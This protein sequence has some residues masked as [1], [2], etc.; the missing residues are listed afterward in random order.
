M[1][2]SSIW[3]EAFRNIKTGTTR[4][5]T[6]TLLLALVSAT[7]VTAEVKAVEQISAQADAFRQKGASILTLA[8]PGRVDGR[9]CEALA[10]IPG[11]LAAGALRGADSKVVPT[12]L[13]ESPVPAFDVTPGFPPLV[14][15][16]TIG[17]GPLAGPELAQSLDLPHRTSIETREGILPIGGTFSYPSDGRR[18][19]FSYALL[20]PVP[21]NSPFDECWIDVWPSDDG[22]AQLLLTTLLPTGNSTELPELSQLNTSLGS[23]FDGAARFKDRVTRWATPGLAFAGA[24]LGLVAIALRRLQIAASLHAGVSRRAQ[25]SILMLEA[26]V[27]TLAAGILATAASAM[28]CLSTSRDMQ[29]LILTISIRVIL[30]G[31]LGALAGT[32]L[33]IALVR[34]DHLFRYFKNR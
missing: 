2:F 31:V 8:A 7:F 28:L 29:T 25:L 11:V 30:A 12:A 4:A 32:A 24:L 10:D 6:F 1:R 16:K 33:A 26:T 17:P 23:S 5:S 34:E 9:G 21:A 13:R 20:M 22:R 19:G 3:R 15:A 18:G 27:W 14:K